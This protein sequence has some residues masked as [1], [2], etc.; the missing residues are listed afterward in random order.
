MGRNT[1]AHQLIME[2]GDHYRPRPRRGRAE[3]DK[4]LH[5]EASMA[6]RAERA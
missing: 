3:A 2:E 4:G 5:R 6:K 1:D